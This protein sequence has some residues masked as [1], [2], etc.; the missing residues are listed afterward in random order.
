MVCLIVD[1][2]VPA[3]ENASIL[4]PWLV[5]FLSLLVFTASFFILEQFSEFRGKSSY[6][7]ATSFAS[8]LVGILAGKPGRG[9]WVPC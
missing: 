2:Y 6:G 9:I 3:T 4:A 8:L 1:N 5:I 7:I